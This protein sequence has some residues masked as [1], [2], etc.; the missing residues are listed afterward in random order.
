MRKFFLLTMAFFVLLGCSSDDNGDPVDD[1]PVDDSPPP[2]ENNAVRLRSDATF[3]NI[4]T[5]SDGFTLYFFSLDSKG[6][7]NCED[8]CLAAWPAFYEQDL[9]LDNGLDASDFGTITRGDGEMQTTYKGWPL[10][11]FANDNAEGDV[12]GDG[13][14]GIW[15]V[16]KPDY[17][18]MM[19]Q[20]Q[21]IGR[22]SNGVETN[23]T[24]TYEAGDEETFYMTDAE[25]NTLYRFING[26]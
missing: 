18:V 22:D 26:R 19:T 2:V 6:D 15:Y 8:G 3:G 24:S 14:G 5:N 1:D 13:S 9:T 23:L 17:S 25:G 12:N 10:Y 20:A 4:L 11:L 16:A 7:S 21:L